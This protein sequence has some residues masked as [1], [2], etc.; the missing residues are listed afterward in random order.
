MSDDEGELVDT[1][2]GKAKKG[3]GKSLGLRIQKKL[4]G[5]TVKS[6]GAAQRFIDDNSGELLDHLHDLALRELGP[7]QAKDLLKVCHRC[8]F[9]PFFPQKFC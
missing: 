5:M 2:T 4:I 3:A 1:A 6:K 9:A 8:I 7:K